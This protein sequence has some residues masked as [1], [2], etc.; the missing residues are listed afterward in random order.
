MV[1]LAAEVQLSDAVTFA[2]KS[3]TDAWQLAFAKADWAGAQLT[4]TG[5]VLSVTVNVVEQVAELFAASLTVI[6]T[7]VTPVET[8]EIGRAHV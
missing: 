2:V 5:A 8:R 6:V 7:F 4:M 3:G 1:R